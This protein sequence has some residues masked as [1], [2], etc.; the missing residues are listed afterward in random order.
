MWSR[1]FRANSTRPGGLLPT[2]SG[3]TEQKERGKRH[4]HELE[5]E[6]YFLNMGLGYMEAGGPKF[7]PWSRLPP[8]EAPSHEAPARDRS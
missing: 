1:G 3:A 6:V 7:L 8:A 5:I 2:T 4:S